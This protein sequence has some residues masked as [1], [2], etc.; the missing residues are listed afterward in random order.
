MAGDIAERFAYAILGVWLTLVAI[1]IID[2]AR[3]VPD[4]I[5]PPLMAAVGFV[6]SR[7][8]I[9]GRKS[10]G[11]EDRQAD[12]EIRQT[13]RDAAQDARDVR[14][15]DREADDAE[16]AREVMRRYLK[17]HPPE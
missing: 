14:Q 2:P 17:D 4:W 15:D 1:S 5:F 11:T 3:P 7:Q 9:A 16:Q 12:R 13:G 10:S 8:V 6:F